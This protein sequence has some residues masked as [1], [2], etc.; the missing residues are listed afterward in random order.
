[1]VFFVCLFLMIWLLFV[2]IGFGLFGEGETVRQ[3]HFTFLGCTILLG[4]VISL[5]HTQYL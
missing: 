1:M 4:F 2:F 3:V 5:G